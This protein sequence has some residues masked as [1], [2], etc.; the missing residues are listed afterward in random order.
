MAPTIQVNR[1]TRTSRILNPRKV[2][3]SADQF[4]QDGY[5]RRAKHGETDELESLADRTS[6]G[7]GHRLWFGWRIAARAGNE[8]QSED[9]SGERN[10]KPFPIWK[11]SDCGKLRLAGMW[12]VSVN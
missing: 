5:D 2:M 7:H 12:E 9:Q 6:V 3:V 11:S 10:Q 1:A 8:G 4:A